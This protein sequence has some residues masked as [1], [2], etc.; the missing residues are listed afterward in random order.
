LHSLKEGR[1]I[2]FEEYEPSQSNRC[3]GLTTGGRYASNA[4][5]SNRFNFIMGH[6]QDSS[7]RE[8]SAQN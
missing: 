2:Y 3:D 1:L 4:S 7:S 6:Q 8:N 5:T